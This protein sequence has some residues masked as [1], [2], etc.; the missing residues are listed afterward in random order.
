MQDRASHSAVWE[1]Y[2]SLMGGGGL[3]IPLLPLSSSVFLIGPWA[4]S[5]SF[6][7]LRHCLI[8]SISNFSLN[9]LRLLCWHAITICRVWLCATDNRKLRD[10]DCRQT[11][12]FLLFFTCFLFSSLFKQH[13]VESKPNISFCTPLCVHRSINIL[14]ILLG[15]YIPQESSHH[16][17]SV[18]CFSVLFHYGTIL[19]LK[20]NNKNKKEEWGLMSTS[21]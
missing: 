3:E 13:N 11:Y 19:W 15:N 9:S 10:K 2:Q 4:F 8:S 17:C 14:S 7:F 18:C 1:T 6:F 5:T 16:F 12:C 20:A 21:S